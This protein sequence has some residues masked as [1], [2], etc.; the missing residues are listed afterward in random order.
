[1]KR[2]VRSDIRQTKLAYERYGSPTAGRQGQSTA[3][4]IGK[5][6]ARATANSKTAPRAKGK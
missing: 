6:S 1:M 3:A 5:W 4:N 2:P